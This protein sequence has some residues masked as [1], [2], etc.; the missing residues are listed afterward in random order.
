[1]TDLRRRIRRGLGILGVLLWT[2]GAAA[3]V[4]LDAVPGGLVEIPITSMDQVR[5]QAFFGQR[6]ILVLKFG[7]RWAG[8]VG[9]PLSLVPGRYVIQ[10]MLEE[11]ETMEAREFTVYPGRRDEQPTTQLPGPPADVFNL[12]LRW[13]E[14]L[15]AEL[16]LDAPVRLPADPLF[17]HYTDQDA[18][19]GS[20][21]IDYVAFR[22]PSDTSVNAPDAGRIAATTPHETGTYIWID[23][24]MGLFTCVGPVTRTT[25]RQADPVEAGQVIGRI[26]LDEEETSKPLYLSVFLNG[27]AVNP[28]LIANIEKNSASVS[29]NR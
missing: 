22:V 15:D 13:R 7:G 21:H 10:V 12:A 14:T 17:G 9:L 8:L 3:Q 26:I 28:F 23:H 5:P 6:P 2:P 25:L 11:S 29:S 1:M 19:F 20:D 16:P 18:G 4:I 24:G 27:T